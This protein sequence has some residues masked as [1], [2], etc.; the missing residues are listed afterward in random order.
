MGRRLPLAIPMNER[1]L[2]AVRFP[3][4]PFRFRPALA[5]L[6]AGLNRLYASDSAARRSCCRH[7]VSAATSA[8]RSRS[9]A[10]ARAAVSLGAREPLTQSVEAVAERRAVKLDVQFSRIRQFCCDGRA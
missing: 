7:A 9:H 1:L 6:S 4:R 8:R 3:E 10:V 5:I 2:V